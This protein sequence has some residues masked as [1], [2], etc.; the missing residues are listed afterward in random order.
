LC[1]LPVLSAPE[2]VAAA[3]FSCT[4]AWHEFLLASVFPMDHRTMTVLI[5]WSMLVVATPYI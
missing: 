3:I 5:K 2:P 4:L 1:I